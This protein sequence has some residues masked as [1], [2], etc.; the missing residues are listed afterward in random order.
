MFFIQIISRNHPNTF[1]LIVVPWC[2]VCHYYTTSFCKGQTQVLILLTV[3]RRFTMVRISDNGPTGNK[4]KRLSSVYHTIKIIHQPVENKML[5]KVKYCNKEYLLRYP[6]A[7]LDS[8]FVHY[9]MSSFCP[10]LDEICRKLTIKT[11]E[12]RHWR[13]SGVFIVNFEHI[14]HLA[15]VFLLLTLSR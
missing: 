13:R 12:R 11:L 5:S 15:P 7:T 10:I 2:S 1:L 8:F 4:T 6:Y 3:C 14:L 9:L